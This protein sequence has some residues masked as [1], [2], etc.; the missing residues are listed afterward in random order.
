MPEKSGI[1]APKKQK[2][3]VPHLL[4]TQ[5]SKSDAEQLF[6]ISPSSIFSG[7]LSATAA[8]LYGNTPIMSSYMS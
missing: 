3:A 2:K 6:Y 4:F 8:D 5:Q 7:R 1:L